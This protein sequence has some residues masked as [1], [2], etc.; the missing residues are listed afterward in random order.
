[1]TCPHWRQTRLRPSRLPR[2]KR[3]PVPSSPNDA[4]TT[5]ST[6]HD[7][8]AIAT[9]SNHDRRASPTCHTGP[10]FDE[11]V[12][13]MV[14]ILSGDG[15]QRLSEHFRRKGIGESVEFGE[16][17]VRYATGTPRTE[18]L[19]R[20]VS[21]KLG[22]EP[23]SHG[24]KIEYQT[25][26]RPPAG[27]TCGHAQRTSQSNPAGNRSVCRDCFTIGPRPQTAPG[28]QTQSPNRH[29]SP[30]PAFQFSPADRVPRSMRPELP[31]ANPPA[32]L[33]E[34]GARTDKV[35]PETRPHV[36]RTS[37]LG[38]AVFGIFTQNRVMVHALILPTLRLGDS[39]FRTGDR[40][41][42]FLIVGLFAA[43]GSVPPM[44]VGCGF[45][46]A[47]PQFR[48][49]TKRTRSGWPVTSN[50]G[51][52]LRDRVLFSPPPD[53]PNAPPGC[54]SCVDIFEPFSAT[55]LRSLTD[56]ACFI[57]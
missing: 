1:M 53:W 19:R 23:N 6:N 7:T 27:P 12:S 55:P 39:R 10:F 9:V 32:E 30:R 16:D 34:G 42:K 13:A 50:D 4:T 15:G 52:A 46:R 2:R 26:Y 8:P 22:T 48:S 5:G 38:R 49:P 43:A 36:P 3:G 45:H 14:A 11:K 51:M 35:E 31:S 25:D 47:C 41:P 28:V 37:R 40:R 56:G 21:T 18:D 54:S 44:C 33:L 24:G 17:P 20:R 29:G 57:A